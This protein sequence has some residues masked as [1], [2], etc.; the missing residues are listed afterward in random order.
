MNSSLD[1]LSLFLL[2]YDQFVQQYSDE[3]SDGLNFQEGDIEY[4]I[5]QLTKI[6]AP[7]ME[8]GTFWNYYVDYLHAENNS[9]E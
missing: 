3:E 1:A 7:A 8:E 2:M 5:Q 6:D 4:L 9:T